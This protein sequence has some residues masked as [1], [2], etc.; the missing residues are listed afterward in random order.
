MLVVGDVHEPGAGGVVVAAEEVVAACRA[1]MYEVGTG[2]LRYQS[3]RSPSGRIGG[4]LAGRVVDAVV[5]PVGRGEGA[6]IAR[7][8]WSATTCT[9]VGKKDW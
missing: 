7:L 9:S 8:A 1:I 3:I 4:R 5:R 6:S 2:M